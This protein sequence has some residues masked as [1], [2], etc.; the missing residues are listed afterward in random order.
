M[1]WLSEWH[2]PQKKRRGAIARPPSP[3]FRRSYFFFFE[4][5]FFF[6]A[7]FFAAFLA[8]FFVAFAMNYS[9]IEQVLHEM[10]LVQV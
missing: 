10:K 8:G 7:G 2:W 3:N 6:A 5:V 4:A 9:P 1:A